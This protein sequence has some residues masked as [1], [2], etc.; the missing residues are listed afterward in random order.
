MA[1]PSHTLHAF[2]RSR[3]QRKPV[4]DF[5]SDIRRRLAALG[6][7]PHWLAQQLKGQR[8]SQASIYNYLREESPSEIGADKLEKM[9]TVIEEEERRRKNQNA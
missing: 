8:V 2:P 4:P 6:V 1:T 7:N 9:L 5:R 3:R